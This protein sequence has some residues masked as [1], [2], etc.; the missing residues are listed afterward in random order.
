MNN[1]NPPDAEHS[2]IVEESNNQSAD[3]IS[4]A[5][6]DGGRLMRQLVR[7][8]VLRKLNCHP[9]INDSARIGRLE[10]E[11]AMTTDSFVVT[12]LFFPGGDIGSLAVHGTVNDLAVSGAIPRFLSLALIIEEGFS[13]QTLDRVLDSIAHAAD[14]AGVQIV[15]GDTK[16][17]PH[18]AA[19][20]L[21]INT[22]G[23]GVHER[24]H[25]PGPVALATGDRLLVSGPVGRHGL[26]VLCAREEL[27]LNPAPV[28][29]S[30]SLVEVCQLL[31]RELGSEIKAMRDATRGG[32]AAVLH[33]WAEECSGTLAISEQQVPVTADVRGACEL[34]GL[35]PIHV[36]NE[37]AMV[38]AVSPNNVDRA[39]AIMRGFNVSSAAAE[40]G[41]VIP[42]QSSPVIIQR[43][44][45][46]PQPLDEL[47]GS[48]LPRIC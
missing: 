29:D 28:S 7:E 2:A 6:G 17:V 16:V 12:P 20:G 30:A 10:G 26:A 5:H 42:R 46:S 48:N 11:L 47:P 22:T 25:P 9:R 1:G 32:V 21:F 37:G 8:H 33:E 4:L 24:P 23:V 27:G 31:Q 15:T 3:R 39:L 19:D 34:L 40:I 41:Q 35:D 38:V 13:L 18:G 45:G 14:G 43:M 44:F 36:A